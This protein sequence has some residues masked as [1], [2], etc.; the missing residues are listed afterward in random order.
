MPDESREPTEKTEIVEFPDKKEIDFSGV[1]VWVGFFIALLFTGFIWFSNNSLKKEIASKE[2]EKSQAVAILNL[3]ENQK[4]VSDV[5]GVK[6]VISILSDVSTN[7]STKKQVL[8]GLYTYITKDVKVSTISMAADGTIG[9]DGATSSYRAVAD[10]MLA[11]KSYKKVSAL[12]LKN[13]SVS[14]DAS[15]NPAERAI[16]SFTF[17]LDMTKEVIKAETP[18][19]ALEGT[20][21]ATSAGDG[22]TDTT[23][24][25]TDSTSDGV[26]T[27]GPSA[28]Q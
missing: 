2:N 15:T 28:V 27:P 3:A 24:P 26:T 23:T 20:T 11:L 17:K 7:Q 6:E 22:T 16:F 9:L 13:V 14:T 12:E 19:S 10:L 25:V 5:L 4:V 8:D 18:S 1:F 21:G